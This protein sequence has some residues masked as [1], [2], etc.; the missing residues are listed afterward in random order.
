MIKQAYSYFGN[1]HEIETIIKEGEV[2]FILNA[3]FTKM[4]FKNRMVIATAQG[5]LQLSIPIQGGRD[6]KTSMDSL[7]IAYDTPWQ[8]LHLKSI[9]S[10]YK[11]APFFEYYEDSL[12]QLYSQKNNYLID[13]LQ[14]CHKWLLIQLKNNWVFVQE[15]GDDANGT[16]IPSLD[17]PKNYHLFAENIKYQ[18]VFEDRIGFLPNLSILD[19]LFCVGGKQAVH[20]LKTS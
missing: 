5:P 14:E 1:I 4:S 19:L 3:P 2:V 12:I 10:N 18:Q 16:V 8:E 13:F 11:R 15:K 6:Q 17:V 20:L 9:L 7:K